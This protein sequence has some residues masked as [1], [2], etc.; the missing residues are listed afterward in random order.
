M[1]SLHFPLQHKDK[2]I[3]A[4]IKF[5]K[6]YHNNLEYNLSRCKEFKSNLNFKNNYQNLCQKERIQ[7]YTGYYSL[8]WAI[9]PCIAVGEAYFGRGEDKLPI[10]FIEDINVDFS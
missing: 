7:L 9:F 2:E 1:V 5:I 10:I 4:E 8:S 6:I 3:L